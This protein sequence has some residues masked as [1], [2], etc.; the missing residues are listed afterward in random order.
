MLS[1]LASCM[2]AAWIP[3]SAAEKPNV[4]FIAV[5]DLVPTLGCY[6]D[7]T[8]LT[9]Q[10]DS[11]ASQGMTFL[12]HHCQWAVCGPS[13]ASMTTSLMPRFL[14]IRPMEERRFCHSTL[15]FRWPDFFRYRLPIY[16]T[17]FSS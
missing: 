15:T 11:L 17:I 8:A 4:L 3:A 6:G 5:D 12:N 10:I 14:S 7:T 13:R 2:A 9:P 1:L 16:T